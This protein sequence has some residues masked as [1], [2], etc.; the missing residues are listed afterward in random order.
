MFLL[1]AEELEFIAKRLEITSIFGPFT[2]DS[3][4][5]PRHVHGPAMTILFLHRRDVI[6]TTLSR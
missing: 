6:G 1:P 2:T 3:I 4:Y 5:A